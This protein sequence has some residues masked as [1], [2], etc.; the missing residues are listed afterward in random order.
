MKKLSKLYDDE[1]NTNDMPDDARDIC[2]RNKKLFM[3]ITKK[4][5]HLL[6]IINGCPD[7]EFQVSICNNISKIFMDMT[8]TYALS[9]EKEEE[10]T[11]RYIG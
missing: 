9:G 2:E 3:D 4:I 1:M 8:V 6:K 10:E 5:E 11:P 7:Y